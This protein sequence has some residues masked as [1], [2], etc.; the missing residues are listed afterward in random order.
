MSLGPI[1]RALEAWETTPPGS[2]A[3]R[4][5]YSL[6]LALGLTLTGVGSIFYQNTGPIPLKLIPDLRIFVPMVTGLGMG[7]L[8]SMGGASRRK[9]A[10]WTAVGVIVVFHLEEATVHWIGPYPG[11][12]TGTRV[13]LLGTAASLLAL[14]SVLLLHVEV[15]STRLRR[16]LLSRGADPAAA[17]AAR[18]ALVRQGTSRLLGLSA[19]VGALGLVVV[20]GEALLGDDASG[21]GYILLVG[22]ALLLALAIVLLR[23]AKPKPAPGGDAADGE[24]A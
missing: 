5:L 22:A 21:G 17:E 20:S 23:I 1:D 7:L 15:E 2:V 13:G 4:A 9:P 24:S 10:L 16:D 18:A 12:I 11:S 6:L 14:L 3:R 19:G 8:A